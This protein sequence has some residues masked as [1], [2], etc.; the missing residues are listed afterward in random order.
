MFSLQDQEKTGKAENIAFLDILIEF[1]GKLIRPDKQA[2]YVFVCICH[3][4]SINLLF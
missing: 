2:V 4:R 3:I 1:S